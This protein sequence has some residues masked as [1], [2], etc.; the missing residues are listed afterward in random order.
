MEHNTSNIYLRAPEPGDLDAL[1]RLEN[2][3]EAPETTTTMVPVSRHMLAEYLDNY[4]AELPDNGSLR[5][6]ICTGEENGKCVG[7]IDFYDYSA[8]DR[9]AKIA[10]IIEAP[11]RRRGYGLAALTKMLELARTNFGMH[12]IAAETASDNSASRA[13][14]EAAGFKTC[15]RLKSWIRV[16]RKFLDVIIYQKF[17]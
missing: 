3:P 16:G 9:R 11:Y 1:Y 15:G 7:T 5:L 10:I 2:A 17:L 14:F 6:M 12:Q 13:L 8:R 4:S